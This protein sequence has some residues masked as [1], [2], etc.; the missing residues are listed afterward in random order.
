MPRY[1]DIDWNGLDVPRDKFEEL[2][3][4]DRV[5]WRNEPA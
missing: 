2:Q 1:E 5:A 4:V 3:S